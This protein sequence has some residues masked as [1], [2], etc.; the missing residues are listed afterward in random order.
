MKMPKCLL[1]PIILCLF[2]HLVH[3]QADL[4][5]GCYVW[6][7]SNDKG[8]R[9]ESTRLLTDAVEDIISQYPSC[10]L[11]QRSRFAKLQ[12]QIAN[13]KTIQSLNAAPLSIKDELKIIQAKRVVFGKVDR[14]FQ[15]SISLRLTFESL[16]STQFKSN[17]IFLT[18]EDY[19]N[20]DKRKDKLTA[21]VNS[22]INPDGKLPIPNSTPTTSQGGD[23]PKKECEPQN[24]PFQVEGNGVKLSLC[25]CYYYS[26]KVTCPLWLTNVT[27]D[28]VNSYTIHVTSN[29]RIIL[30]YGKEYPGSSGIIMSNTNGSDNVVRNNIPTSKNGV[31][32]LIIFDKV[33]TQSKVL[34]S[35]EINIWNVGVKSFSDV[36]LIHGQPPQR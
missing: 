22:F 13:E 34:E 24:A 4:C 15:G 23:S 10:T 30:D 17:T 29:T 35:L 12:E 1:M 5:N 14:D 19:Y 8:E 18:G 26:N 28:I 33:Q 25:K 31:P 21:F 20:F 16:I 6:A 2:S 32:A 27:K 36:P 3:A 9:D 11:L 7:F